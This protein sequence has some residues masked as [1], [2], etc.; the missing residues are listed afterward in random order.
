MAEVVVVVMVVSRKRRR[1][2]FKEELG[3]VWILSVEVAMWS[4]VG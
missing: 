3:W 4:G 1:L 2:G